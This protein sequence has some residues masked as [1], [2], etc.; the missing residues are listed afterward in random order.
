MARGATST[1]VV[2]NAGLAIGIVG[3]SVIV[4]VEVTQLPGP[5]LDPF[6]V[7][8]DVGPLDVLRIT[9]LIR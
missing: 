9:R 4:L 7:G 2:S 6:Q 3:V 1:S 5:H 8:V